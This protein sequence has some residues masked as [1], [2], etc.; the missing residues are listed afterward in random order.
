MDFA[1]RGKH[2]AGRTLIAVQLLGEPL[3]ML[4]ELLSSAATIV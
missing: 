2:C 1:R 4:Q 3:T